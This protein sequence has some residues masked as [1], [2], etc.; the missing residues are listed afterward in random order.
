MHPCTLAFRKAWIGRPKTAFKKDKKGA[1]GMEANTTFFLCYQLNCHK[2][3]TFTTIRCSLQLNAT[4]FNFWCDKKFEGD[5][6]HS[7]QMQVS[8]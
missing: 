6:F 2:G 1:L 3:F 7:M 8:K 5:E 4:H